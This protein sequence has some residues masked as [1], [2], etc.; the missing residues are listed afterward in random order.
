MLGV[1]RIAALIALSLVLS[2]ATSH[3]GSLD[4]SPRIKNRGICPFPDKQGMLQY[5]DYMGN[6]GVC[7][8]ESPI[9]KHFQSNVLILTHGKTR[10]SLGAG[11]LAADC[12][13][14]L[15]VSHAFEQGLAARGVNYKFVSASNAANW[16]AFNAEDVRS[17]PLQDLRFGYDTDKAAVVLSKSLPCRPIKL[18]SMTSQ[19]LLAEAEA[20][21]S[22]Y[23]IKLPFYKENGKTQW[24][25]PALCA[26][27]CQIFG[28]E[29]G[30]PKGYVRDMLVHDCDTVGGNSGSP[31]V[32]QKRNGELSG[33]AIHVGGAVG[34]G[35]KFER[36]K[37]YNHAIPT[38]YWWKK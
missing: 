30:S 13:S 4:K 7:D 20:G 29:Y 22:F 11:L 19:Q 17:D 36:G 15:T 16:V 5:A 27:K 3:A 21:A 23:I 31:I 26:Q 32:M 24:H 25:R 8:Y 18:E 14:V 12:K 37:T 35:S 33:V 1:L 2:S 9:V 38:L 6:D 34:A 10:A 28:P